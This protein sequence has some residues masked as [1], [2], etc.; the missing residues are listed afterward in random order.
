MNRIPGLR[1]LFRLERPEDVTETVEDEL[2]FH[3]DT[4]V[5][6]LMASGMDA[7]T[8]R[9]EAERRF[10]DVGTVRERLRALDR[11]RIASERRA[12]WWGGLAQ[13]VRYA[14]RGL[15][16]RPGFAVA[17]ILT[18]GLGIGANA[19]MFGIV[20]QLM[21]RPPAYLDRPSDVHRV[22]FATSPE[23][24]ERVTPNTSI[25]RY[26]DMRDWTH[27]FDEV[28]AFWSSPLAVGVGQ[29]AE[30]LRVEGVSAS[31]WRLFDVRPTAGRLFGGDEDSLPEA[32]YVAVLTNQ[33]WRS[34]FGG[35]VDVLGQQLRIGRHV[36]SIIGVAPPGFTGMDL[37]QVAVFV[38]LTAMTGEA[39]NSTEA[40]R[41]YGYNWIEL[42][43]RR[44]PE[45][46]VAAA[47]ADLTSAFVR[48]YQ[49]RQELEGPSAR[50]VQHDKPRAIAAPVLEMRGPDASSTARVTLWLV[51]VSAIVLI[52]ACAN[53]A[54]LLLARTFGRR[55]EIAVR[56][57]LGVSRGR[58]IRQ[59]LTESVLLAGL[60][61]LAAV[62]LAQL[63]G[64]L[65]R[66]SLLQGV[67][68][69]SS[70]NDGRVLI[71]TAALALLAG[72]VT[73]LIPA[74]HAGRSDVA[75]SLKAGVREGTYQRSLARTVMLVVQA[76][77]SVVLLVGAGL[78]VRSL[79]RALSS[80]LGYDAEHVLYVEVEMRE[81]TLDSSAAGQL[82]DRLLA[83]VTAL[84]MVEHAARQV[85]V[86][87]WMD[88]EE[89]LFVAG[90]DSVGR[91]GQFEIQAGSPD[92]FA[93][94]GTRVLRGRGIEAA[95]RHGSQRVMVVSQSMAS[96][97]WP[98]RDAIGQ[99]VRVGSD[100]MPCT[101]VVGI[102]EDTKTGSL[103]ESSLMHYRPI[104]QAAP[105]EG[106]L[107][108]RVRGPASVQ[109]ESVRRALLPLM[110]GSA[111]VKVTPLAEIVGGPR[112]SLE[113]G[114]MMFTLF[115][116]LA[117]L[118]AAV[119]LYSVVSYG[120]AQ[121]R[122]ELGVRVA[123]GAQ[124][125]DIIGMVV[126]DGVRLTGV[127]V[128]AGLLVAWAA[129]RWIAPLLFET[130][131]HD[132]LVLVGVAATLFGVSIAASMIPARRAARV[133]PASALRGE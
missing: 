108:V 30:E 2:D 6:E 49:A 36:Y 95:D 53:V 41:S 83:R 81:V 62:G 18:L 123:L 119:G 24:V 75:G 129:G 105:D 85:T 1:R 52:I 23:G 9:A 104:D 103:T 126:A 42:V 131:P 39:F 128:A 8:A 35:R 121:R 37:R 117:L 31:F 64:G 84:P 12:E 88:W 107:F 68:W 114:A 118:V 34:H 57:A 46:S 78:F 97:L 10:G 87:F 13:D 72:V 51:G 14:T 58:L 92:Y 11:G 125:R 5:Q 124:I 32:S 99:C 61:G 110:P 109:S 50:T 127:A 96:R 25:H 116:A 70:V 102:A 82:R 22:Y 33:Y 86:P 63:G 15:R 120:V 54:N 45:V 93:T 100:T 74:W 26:H 21:L 133:D 17:I 90:I 113:L 4:A 106:G 101:M 48:S 65:L 80:R 60:G 44:R 38:P 56:L 47:G 67:A 43:V 3:F 132:P 59:L 66:A 115:G 55:R 77:L 27:S 28:A 76:A 40:S 16:L 69:S 7:R 111:Y 71:V 112:R 130:S 20:D 98:G 122:H 91:L 79:H 89:D 73:G 19:M 94:M 29:D